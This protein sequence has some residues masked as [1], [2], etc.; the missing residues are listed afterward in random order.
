MNGRER[1]D[2]RPKPVRE[3]Q[4]ISKLPQQVGDLSIELSAGIM[5]A[6]HV[7]QMPAK[8]APGIPAKNLVAIPAKEVAVMPSK[9]SVAIPAKEVAGMLGEDIA[10]ID[11]GILTIDTTIDTT[12]ATT[13]ATFPQPSN[14]TTW[15]H[16]KQNTGS[17]TSSS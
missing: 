14:G 6:K 1:G 2:D 8:D 15:A 17:N 9:N 7:A 10:I 5:V 13:I 12:I 11:Q 3:A 4:D 16:L